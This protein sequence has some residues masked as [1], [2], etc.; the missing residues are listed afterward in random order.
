[1]L[2]SLLVACGTSVATVESRPLVEAAPQPEAQKPA[3]SPRIAVP[4]RLV[5]IGDLHGDLE[6]AKKAFHLAGV[7]DEQGRWTG[8]DTTLVQTGDVLDRGPDGKAL[9]DWLMSVESGAKAAGGRFVALLGNHEVMNVRGDLRYVSAEDTAGFG[10][11][12]ER[13]KAFSKEGAYGRWLAT[14]DAVAIVGDTLF[15]HG[16]L[17]EE[18]AI[19]GT[20]ALN[21]DVRAS[22]FGTSKPAAGPD[23]PLW[24]RGF[25]LDD[26]AV[27]CPRL[28]R[29]LSATG[30]RRMVVG[31]TMQDSG[32]ILERCGGRLSVVDVG[33]S[34]VYDGG[35]LAAWE[36]S[37]GDAVALYPAGKSDLADP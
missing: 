34:R 5:A 28:E 11:A 19:R 18:F 6:Q 31:H 17:T 27:A 15:C 9:L 10:G 25:V 21:S 13:A 2:W 29:A 22:L 12:T 4:G 23:G 16:G 7:T 37:N 26:E 30:A 33:I 20:E 1:M 36:Q 32:R 8:G 24:Y 14:H 3:P 35:H